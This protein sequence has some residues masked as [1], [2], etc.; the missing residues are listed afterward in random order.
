[1]GYCFTYKNIVGSSVS[2]TK[3]AW[4]FVNILWFINH[5]LNLPAKILDNI[6]TTTS[7]T[8]L[9]VSLPCPQ[10][11]LLIPVWD[12]MTQSTLS[13]SIFNINLNIIPFYTRLQIGLYPS[14]FLTKTVSHVQ[15]L[16]H[17]LCPSHL[18]LRDF[19]F[20]ITLVRGTN[21]GSP[22]NS[23]SFSLLPLPSYAQITYTCAFVKTKPKWQNS[24]DV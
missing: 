21:D 5:L 6:F 13:H 17:A 4:N 24:Q 3:A 23:V 18:I 20:V 11:P 7:N 15:A 2:F 22:H 12:Q 8:D 14:G 1:M 19:I 9:E 10:I 16:M